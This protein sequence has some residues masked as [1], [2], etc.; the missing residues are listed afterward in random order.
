MGFAFSVELYSDI[1]KIAKKSTKVKDNSGLLALLLG[2]ETSQKLNSVIYKEATEQ[3]IKNKDKAINDA[4]KNNRLFLSP[5]VFYL[6]SGHGDCAID[7]LPYQARI[8]IDADWRDAIEDN[9]LKSEIQKYI[10]KNNTKT[11]QWVIGKP[12]WLIT[13]KN[14]RHYFKALDFEEVNKNTTAQLLAKYN[15]WH[16]IGQRRQQ[17][18]Q[19]STKKAWYNR[20][21]IENLIKKYEQRHALYILLAKINNTPELQQMIRKN[22]FLIRKWKNY[23][24]NF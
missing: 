16:T 20:T 18:I 12:V 9:E 15:M 2:N 24:K 3:E 19:H 17:T 10:R 4:L 7:H 22:L 13:R 21:N 11:F 8:Y 5:K 23:L 6:I 1:L 14:C